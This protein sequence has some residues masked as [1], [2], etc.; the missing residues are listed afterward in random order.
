MAHVVWTDQA[1][2]TKYTVFVDGVDE[3][4]KQA[5]LD[6]LGV[7]RNQPVIADGVVPIDPPV[8]KKPTI[9][10]RIVALESKVK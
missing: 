5:I 8:V 2:K 3:P 10:E 7:D 1:G 6:R 9:E 4:T